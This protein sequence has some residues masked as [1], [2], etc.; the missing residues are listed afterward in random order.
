[1]TVSGFKRDINPLLTIVCLLL[2]DLNRSLAIQA[3]LALIPMIGI[4][5]NDQSTS[6]PRAITR[7]VCG[8]LV[9]GPPPQTKSTTC[10]YITRYLSG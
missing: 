8:I 2:P 1:M 9:M 7:L 4:T 3:T 5:F 10:I 6:P